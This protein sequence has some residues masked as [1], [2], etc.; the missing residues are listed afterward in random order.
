MDVEPSTANRTPEVETTKTMV[1]RIENRFGIKLQ[2]LI[3]GTAYGTVAMRN[4][5]VEEKHIEPLRTCTVHRWKTDQ[6][7]CQYHTTPTHRQYRTGQ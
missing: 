1:N 3:G 5:I 4:W 7:H 6:Y 2:R